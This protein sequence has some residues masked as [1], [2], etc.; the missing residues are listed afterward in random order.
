MKKLLQSLVAIAS[1]A[2]FSLSCMCVEA[3]P[4]QS[5]IVGAV[6]GLMMIGSFK[7]LGVIE[8]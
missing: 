1:A 5:F 7:A 4:W 6:S 3:M 8:W 2:G